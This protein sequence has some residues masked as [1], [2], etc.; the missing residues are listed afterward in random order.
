MEVSSARAHSLAAPKADITNVIYTS[1]A[2][3]G[4]PNGTAS[5]DPDCQPPLSDPPLTDTHD[6]RAQALPPACR[7]ETHRTRVLRV[8]GPFRPHK[9]IDHPRV[10]STAR[11]T[12]KTD[13]SIHRLLTA[14]VNPDPRSVAAIGQRSTPDPARAT[15]ARAAKAANPGSDVR[16]VAEA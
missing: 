4:P 2:L 9:A 13:V 8:L 5:A 14:E 6:L 10:D 15:P 3:G 12:G 1:P 11:Q 16:G 7:S